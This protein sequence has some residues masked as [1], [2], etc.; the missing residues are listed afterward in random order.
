MKPL[1]VFLQKLEK[2]CKKVLTSGRMCG[3]ILERQ[4]LRQKNDFRVSARSEAKRT[5]RRK[6]VRQE[7]ERVSSGPSSQKTKNFEKIKLD[8]KPLL[9]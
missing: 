8:K 7:C 3:I 9:W 6:K 5:N 4:A 2:R 1:P